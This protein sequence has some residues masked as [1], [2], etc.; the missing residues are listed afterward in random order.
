MFKLDRVTVSAY[1][2]NDDDDVPSFSQLTS[3]AEACLNDVMQ[4]R[5]LVV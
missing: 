5:Q 1:L 2:L 4:R 3:T